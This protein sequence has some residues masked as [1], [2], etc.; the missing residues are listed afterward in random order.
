MYVQGVN[1]KVID[2]LMPWGI[3]HALPSKASGHGS[4]YKS[5]T[6]QRVSEKKIDQKFNLNVLNSI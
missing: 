1:L 2:A 6:S 4:M 5:L 3:S